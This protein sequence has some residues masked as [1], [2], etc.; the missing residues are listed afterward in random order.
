MDEDLKLLEAELTRLQPAAPSRALFA[1]VER[2]LGAAER[3]PVVPLRAGAGAARPAWFWALSAPLAAAAAL[4]VMFTRVPTDGRA[5]S[6][7]AE[8][9]RAA[10]AGDDSAT[11]LKPVAAE[12][13]L[14]AA[15]DEGFVTLDDGTPARRERLRYVDTITWRNPRTNASLTWSV[16]RD[17]VRIVPVLF[18]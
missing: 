9:A 14:Y 17:E 13:V 10:S 1:R 8:M 2:Q 3:A 7:R 16:P 15:S 5:P 12:N 4:A 11:A 18:Q 6:A